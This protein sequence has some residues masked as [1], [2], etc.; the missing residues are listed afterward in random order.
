[1]ADNPQTHSNR[2]AL[3]RRLLP[4]L[5][6]LGLVALIIGANRDLWGQFFDRNDLA[7][8]AKLAIRAPQFDGQ[9]NNGQRFRLSAKAGAQQD[10][11]AV[12][13]S[14]LRLSI[15]PPDDA[16]QKTQALRAQA[17]NGR[18]STVTN[19]AQFSGTVV[20]HDG[21]GNRLDT[22]LLRL[23]MA[24]GV[25]AA[26]QSVTLKGPGGR[27]RAQSLTADTQSGIYEFTNITM[28]LIRSAP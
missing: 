3:L 11:G 23:D 9:L 18:F 27:L 8:A 28:R 4:I 15:A 25:I 2:V 26:P 6:G 12:S 14:D 10:D 5:A 7:M 24:D 16:S 1:M 17:D 20:L 13:L 22:P 21:Y 19:Q